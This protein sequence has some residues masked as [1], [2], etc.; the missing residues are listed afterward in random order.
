MKIQ[1]RNFAWTLTSPF[2]VNITASL[3]VLIWKIVKR[4][5]QRLLISHYIETEAKKTNN[6]IKTGE[7]SP[8]CAAGH[9][10]MWPGSSCNIIYYIKLK[11]TKSI[12]WAFW[13]DIWKFVP[14]KISHYMVL[15]RAYRPQRG[16]GMHLAPGKIQIHRLKWWCSMEKHGFRPFRRLVFF[17]KKRS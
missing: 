10:W 16:E 13:T 11:H 3:S 4:P 17:P 15:W 6:K 12:L 5:T 7:R 1:L 8:Y 9:R 2:V 14:M